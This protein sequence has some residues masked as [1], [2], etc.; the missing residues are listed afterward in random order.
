MGLLLR[1]GRAARL[2]PLPDLPF[3]TSRR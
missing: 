1:N 2:Y 3:R